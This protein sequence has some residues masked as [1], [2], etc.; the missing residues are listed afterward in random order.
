MSYVDRTD[1]ATLLA[2]G[3]ARQARCGWP[4]GS[5]RASWQPAAGVVHRDLKPGNVMAGS[6]DDAL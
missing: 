6:G 5:A 2:R 4:G 1:L 3:A